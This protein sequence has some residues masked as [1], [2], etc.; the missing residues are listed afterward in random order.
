MSV[1]GNLPN[2]VRWLKKTGWPYMLI[3][4]ECDCYQ[5]LWSI[6]LL[7]GLKCSFVIDDECRKRNW[8]KGLHQNSGTLQLPFVTMDQ[9]RALVLGLEQ[10]SSRE[11]TLFAPGSKNAGIGRK[12]PPKYDFYILENMIRRLCR[13]LIQINCPWFMA[14]IIYACCR[15]KAKMGVSLNIIAIYR[16]F[17]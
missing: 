14:I 8:C 16:M 6:G 9:R 17:S 2:V 4:P 7:R 3:C 12:F 1:A 15:G 11:R 13:V 5:M 10:S